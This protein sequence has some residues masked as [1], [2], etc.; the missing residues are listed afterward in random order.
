MQ[1]IVYI[2]AATLPVT[3]ADLQTYLRQWRQNNERDGITGVLLYSEQEQRFMQ[4]IEGEEEPLRRLFK[5]IQQ[6][7]RHRDLLI[8]A[9]GPIPARA[10]SSWLMGFQVLST[11]AFGQL[12]GYID[13]Q[14]ET[15]HQALQGSQDELIRDLLASFSSERSHGLS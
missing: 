13:P 4:L 12:A 15:F 11:E 5:L 6:D 9:D 8:L 10:F 1:H 14:S 2:S 7:H 3:E